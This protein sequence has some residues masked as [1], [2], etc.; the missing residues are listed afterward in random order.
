MSTLSISLRALHHPIT[1][2]SIGVLL[3]NDHILKTL[4]PNAVT[5]KLSD[6]AGLFFFPFLLTT[7]LSLPL[8]RLRLSSRLIA[9]FAFSSTA[10]WFSLIKTTF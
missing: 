5:G 4:S 1:I 6:F 9:A 3:L 8:E 2:L 7:F 10:I